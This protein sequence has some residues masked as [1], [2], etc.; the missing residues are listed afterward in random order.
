MTLER[1][2]LR[3]QMLLRALW[4]DARPGVLA[5]W[6]RD[7][8]RFER[9]LAAYRANA[10]A[11][12]ARALQAAYPTVA[13][14]LGEES[15]A[16]FA[17]AFW[18]SHPP[19]R[20]DIAEWGDAL[21]AFIA[22]DA[23]LAAEP[24]LADVASLDWALHRA[25]AAADDELPAQDLALL[26]ERAPHTVGV[27]FR[28]GAALVQSPWPVVSIW[29]AH[30]GPRDA[31]VRTAD[32]FASVRAALAARQGETAWVWREGFRARVRALDADAARCMQVLLKGGSMAAALA[33]AGVGFDVER[34]LHEAL[35]ADW[36]ARVHPLRAG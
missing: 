6:T 16:L 10:A 13:A 8:A 27:R 14:L 4:R 22:G 36:I 31:L 7:G 18:Q 3:Q 26:A 12:A 11:L 33:A 25:V 34:W 1:E 21:P 20:G 30:W 35:R 23:Q 5:G 29:L 24:Y 17:R 28:A 9:G 2:V 32:A 15:F 19:L